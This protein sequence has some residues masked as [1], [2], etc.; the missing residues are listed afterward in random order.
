MIHLTKELEK[1]LFIFNQKPLSKGELTLLA[2]AI[3]DELPCPAADTDNMKIYVLKFKIYI[4]NIIDNINVHT[5]INE[6]QTNEL[7]TTVEEFLL[8]RYS[9]AHNPPFI[10][11]ING[12]DSVVSELSLLPRYVDTA[13]LCTIGDVY[14]NANFLYQLFRELAIQVKTGQND[15]QPKSTAV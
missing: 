7:I 11:F 8:W 2:K 3:S 6:E 14:N 4:L 13:K 10:L 9:I 1:K 5:Y 12:V 15:E